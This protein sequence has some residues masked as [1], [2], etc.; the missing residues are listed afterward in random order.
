MIGLHDRKLDGWADP[1][2]G[3]IAPGVPVKAGMQVVDVGCGDGGYASFCARMGANLTFLDI[4]E[5]K[6]AAL[7]GLLQQGDFPGEFKGIVT[8]CNPIPL[9]DNYADLIISTEVLEHVPDPKMFLDEMVRIG[10][11]DATFV[12]TVPDA[13]GENLI[14]A[15]APDLYF[16]EPNHIQIFTSDEFEALAESCGLEVISH[17]YVGAFWAIFFL[18]KWASSDGQKEINEANHPMTQH[19]TK[20]WQE[21][22]NHPQR[23]DIRQSLNNAVPSSQV[24][25]ARKRS[26]N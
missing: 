11:D 22:L 17:R 21:I 10:K 4:Q 8:E 9:P 12:L 18:L 16:K 13:R 14:K 24:I 20:V 6:V 7:E 25:V 15:T 1:D 19:W 3:E 5:E 23:E 2:T 26:G